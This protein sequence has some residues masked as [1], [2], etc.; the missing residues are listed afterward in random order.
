MGCWENELELSEKLLHLFHGKHNSQP[1]WEA[2]SVS[3]CACQDFRAVCEASPL[4]PHWLSIQSFLVPEKASGGTPR[5]RTRV[6]EEVGEQGMKG[7]AV[8]RED[9]EHISRG[10]KQIL[11]RR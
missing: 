2:S 8:Q 6:P 10:Q 4:S 9:A 5:G 1:L 3:F 7:S 11:W